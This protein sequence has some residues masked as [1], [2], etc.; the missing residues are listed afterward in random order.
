MFE[1]GSEAAATA[2]ARAA[3]M[4]GLLRVAREVSRELAPIA[5]RFSSLANDHVSRMYEVDPVLEP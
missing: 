2:D 4:A 5:E 3:G 1:R